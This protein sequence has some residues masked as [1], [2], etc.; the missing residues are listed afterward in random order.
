[1][2]NFIP[3]HLEGTHQS[4]SASGSGFTKSASEF[5]THSGVCGLVAAALGLQRDDPIIDSLHH[6]LRVS[7]RVLKQGELQTEY[8][9]FR[10]WDVPELKNPAKSPIDYDSYRE[11]TLQVLPKGDGNRQVWRTYHQGAAFQIVLEVLDTNPFSANQILE[12]LRHPAMP[13]YLG[14]RTCR[15]SYPLVGKD[16]EVVV[17]EHPMEV[18]SEVHPHV[19]V[20]RGNSD[21]YLG[22]DY[23]KA[24][25]DLGPEMWIPKEGRVLPM[26]VADF[27]LSN[28]ARSFTSRTAYLCIQEPVT[29]EDFEL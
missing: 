4:W 20:M 16:T 21:G 9:N 12:A 26:R 23:I 19:V 18:F 11:E 13:L 27:L 24:S 25:L 3:L 1:M 7:S 22:L 8:Q 2:S 15:L 17:A 6:G 5:P 29:V 10:F 28:R 14:R